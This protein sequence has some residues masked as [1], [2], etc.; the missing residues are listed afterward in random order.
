M[1]GRLICQHVE[2]S[3][4]SDSSTKTAARD[5]GEL[6]P[7]QA[8]LFAASGRPDPQPELF[9]PLSLIDSAGT[10]VFV[11]PITQLL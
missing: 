9:D 6:Q 1:D 3:S 7:Q 2:S 5:T 4:D 10:I 8:T 11:Q